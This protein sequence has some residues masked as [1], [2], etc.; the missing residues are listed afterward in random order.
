MKL[1]TFKGSHWTI[2][3]L[4]ENGK[5]TFRVRWK[6]LKSLGN[7]TDGDFRKVHY[8]NSQNA[9]KDFAVKKIA[10]IQHVGKMVDALDSEARARILR[11]AARLVHRG[12]DP[13]KAMEEGEKHL[14][15]FSLME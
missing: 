7:P 6:N 3:H 15:P 8:F 4:P 9:A 2:S 10:E 11:E 5:K 1:K 12:I 13:M 14:I